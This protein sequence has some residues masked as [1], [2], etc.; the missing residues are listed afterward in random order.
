MSAAPKRV[1]ISIIVPVKNEA[2]NIRECLQHLLWA[3]EIFLVDSQSTDGTVQISEELGA[4]IVQF[5]FNGTYP[6]KKNWA[7]ENLPFR[8]EWVMV[9]DADEL[10]TDELAD[11]IMQA[12]ERGE[13]DGYYISR[14][15]YFLGRW[16]RHCGYY[17]SYNLRLFKHR[18]G[19][20]E[21]MIAAGAGDNEVHEHVVFKGRTGYLRNDMLHYAYPN[22]STWVE[23]HDRYS[24]WE[25]DLY[26]RFRSGDPGGA[27]QHIGFRQR[28]KR[29][30]KRI[31]LGLPLRFVFRFFYAYIWKRG[32]LDGRPGFILCVLLAFYDFLSWAKV[33][34]KKTKR[35]VS[36][37]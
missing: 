9:V 33:Y 4:K 3:D 13:C 12:V 8:N 36:T 16:I 34:E 1:P 7:L 14:R 22:I 6:K 2:G 30:L 24:N 26:E 15:F 17:P 27:E 11:E 31:Y 35:Q 23:K 5:H 32:F 29:W 28:L 25:A 18:L 20:Y 10:V 21:K 37:G 19:R